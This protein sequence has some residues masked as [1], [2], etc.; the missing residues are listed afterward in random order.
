[1]EQTDII[2]GGPGAYHADPSQPAD[3]SVTQKGIMLTYEGHQRMEPSIRMVIQN[4]KV[5]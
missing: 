4:M 1:M 5:F 2:N 3:L